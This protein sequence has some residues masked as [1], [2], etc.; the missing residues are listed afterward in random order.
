[1]LKYNSKMHTC[2][3]LYSISLNKIY[4]GY[5][6][7]IERRLKQHNGIISG[8]AKKT[9][10]GRPWVLYIKIEGFLEKSSALR[11]EYR[12]NL[13]TKKYKS[14]QLHKSLNALVKLIYMGDGS[15]KKDTWFPWPELNVRVSKDFAVGLC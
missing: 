2:Y 10:E 3:I 1:M 4:V 14:D 5:T 9:C 15:K 11:F 6:V 13:M 7:N 12:L 8:G